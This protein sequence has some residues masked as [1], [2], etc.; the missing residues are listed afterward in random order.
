LDYGVTERQAKHWD[1]AFILTDADLISHY[2]PYALGAPSRSVSVAV[3]STARLDPQSTQSTATTEERRTAMSR[4]LYALALHLFGHLNGLP[5]HQDTQGCMYEPETVDDLDQMT[6][7][8]AAQVEQLTANLHEVADLRLEEEPTVR[9]RP[10]W[11]YV[12]GVWIS[13]DGIMSAIIRA[14]PWEFPFRLTRLTTAAISA[15]L[16]LLVTAEVWDVGMTQP[17][18]SVVSSSLFAL[19]LTS[20]YILKRQRLLTRREASALSEQIVVTDISITAVVLL[21]MFTTYM[22]LFTGALGCSTLLFRRQVVAGW[23][24]SLSG[25]IHAMHYVVLSAFV[26]SLSLAIGA[27]GAS[28]EQHYYFRHITYIDEE[29]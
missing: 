15:L 17:A 23:A 14:K 5:H 8:T 20:T 29:T 16:L 19:L 26:A 24:V 18:S 12:R 7:F 28:F 2:K 25:D 10:F 27:L 6:H 22:L 9:T 4:R 13:R 21:G 3:M 1:F 11:F